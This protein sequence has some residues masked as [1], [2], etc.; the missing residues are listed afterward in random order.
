[1][2]AD[3]GSGTDIGP[4][5]PSSRAPARASPVLWA[6]GLAVSDLEGY[7][8]DVLDAEDDVIEAPSPAAGYRHPVG[9]VEAVQVLVRASAC[10]ARGGPGHLTDSRV[11]TIVL[12]SQATAVP[13]VFVAPYLA[14]SDHETHL[15]KLTRQSATTE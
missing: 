2:N 10:R 15:G 1:M 7:G 14:V 12:T 5:P 9:L 4:P 13:V 3:L 11:D 8:V 6:T